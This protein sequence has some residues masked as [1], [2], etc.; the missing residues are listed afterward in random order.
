MALIDNH[1]LPMIDPAVEGLP[2]P[3]R[4]PLGRLAALHEEGSETQALARFLAG[5]VSAAGALM[6]LAMAILSFAAG[7]ALLPCFAWSLLV[8][9][10]VCLL[11]RSYIRSTAAASVT[12]SMHQAA[13]ELRALLVYCG[14]AWGAGGLMVLSPDV[15]VPVPLI[16]A[17]LPTLVLSMLLKDRDG[18]LAFLVPVTGLTIGAAI[19]RPWPDAGLDT[20]LLLALQ[21]L[22]AAHILMGARRQSGPAGLALR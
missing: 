9:I 2:A 7:T 16:F 22:I 4:D 17:A 18:A 21:S 6:L 15:S 8:L 20:A 3:A 11:L 1:S 10:G 5:A 14:F 12:I 13:T 19:L